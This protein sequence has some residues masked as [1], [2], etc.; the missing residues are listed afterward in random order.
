MINFNN[1]DILSDT[2]AMM[3]MRDYKIDPQK[4]GEF[5]II[6]TPETGQLNLT[7]PM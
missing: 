6:S 3:W 7:F 5:K 2:W 4:L 1:E